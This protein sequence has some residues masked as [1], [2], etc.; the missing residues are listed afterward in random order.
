MFIRFDRIHERDGQTDGQTSQ[1]DGIG[2]ALCIASR[3]K[4]S[5]NCRHETFSIFTGSDSKI[6]TYIYLTTKGRLASD[7]LQ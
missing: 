4:N 7:M 5:Y 6:H 1:H 3:G 2:C